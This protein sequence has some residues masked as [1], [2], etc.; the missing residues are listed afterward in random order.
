MPLFNKNDYILS[1]LVHGVS[2]FV[3]DIHVDVYKDL[4]VLF[5]IDQGMFKQYF[6]RAAFEAA[7]DKGVAF[8]SDDHAFSQ[9]QNSLKDH[10]SQ[11]DSFYET[12]I[13][14][15]E[16]LS[17]DAVKTL[18]D[19]TTKLCKDYTLMNI[20]HT[21][22][23]FSLQENSPIIKKNLAAAAAFKDWVRS[24]MN[25]V[26]FEPNGYVSEAFKILGKQFGLQPYV[27]HDCTQQEILSLFDGKPINKEI[28]AKRQ[29]AFVI[30]HDRNH[31][32]QGDD[33]QEIIDEFKEAVASVNSLSGKVASV[34]KAKGPVKVIAVDY[35]DISL[36]NDE[37]QK[38]NKGDILIAQTTAPE[39]IVACKKA[40]AIVTD[41]GGMLSHAAIV[42][43][44]FG[45]PC[46]VG[47][48][49]AT[50]VFKDGDLVEVD[51]ERGIVRKADSL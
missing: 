17:K 39:L 24:Y 40:A 30:N 25:V 12:S 6:E 49:Y 44:E 31:L 15:H 20:E 16:V 13:K 51:A 41:L 7:L 50:Q 18:F 29:Q 45:I 2:V 10:C 48:E 9:Y 32:Y 26:L 28:I 3:T 5:L 19:F 14:N 11:F 35:S 33:A 22:K 27:L 42:S 38:M 43:R 4:G 8:Y 37:I 46:I 1:F 21:D 36:L 23:A 34:G 47:T